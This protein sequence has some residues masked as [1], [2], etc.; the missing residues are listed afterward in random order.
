VKPHDSR[1]G[2]VNSHDTIIT[3]TL[4]GVL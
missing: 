1:T 2:T 3:A 4:R